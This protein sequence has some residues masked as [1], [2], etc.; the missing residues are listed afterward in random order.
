MVAAKAPKSR[1]YSGS[2]SLNVRVSAQR[3]MGQLY[4]CS[5][6]RKSGLQN[7]TIT[8]QL[9]K[10]FVERAKKE[11]DEGIYDSIG[12]KMTGPGDSPIGSY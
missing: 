11:E 5:V 1:H 6:F 2:N 7:Y 12:K 3:N 9:A 8:Q 4:L 10:K